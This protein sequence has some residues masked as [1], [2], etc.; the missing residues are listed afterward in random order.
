[1]DADSNYSP[2]PWMQN[3]PLQA[4]RPNTSYQDQ[5]TA[6]A[7]R[8]ATLDT[9]EEIRN[10]RPPVGGYPFP[11]RFGYRDTALGIADIVRLDNIYTRLDFSG[12]QS[13]YQGTSYPSL[14]Q[15]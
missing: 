11:V 13:G 10:R 14:N 8:S 9:A 1:M 3:V 12:K 15:F 6:D 7:L 2:R 5:L 4:S